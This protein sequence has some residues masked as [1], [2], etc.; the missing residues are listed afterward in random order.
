MA[1]INDVNTFTAAERSVVKFIRDIIGKLWYK[2]PKSIDTFYMHVTGYNL[3]HCLETN[4]GGLHPTELVSLP[5]DILGFYARTNGIQEYIDN[6]K[7]ARRK[8]ARGNLPMLDD[9]VL[10]IA[11]ASVMASHHFSCA[12]D[13]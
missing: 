9:A 6:L 8:L 5:Q 3:L 7:E 2:D 10:A 12:T 1:L 13:D 4:C 11:L